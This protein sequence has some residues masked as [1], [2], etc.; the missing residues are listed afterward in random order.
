MAIRRKSRRKRVS[1]QA[2][3]AAKI[4][5][6]RSPIKTLK[7]QHKTIKPARTLLRKML[8]RAGPPKTSKRARK[9]ATF[10][11]KIPRVKRV[12]LVRGGTR[13]LPRLAARKKKTAPKKSPFRVRKILGMGG[14]LIEI[15]H[16]ISY[17]DYKTRFKKLLSDPKYK[18]LKAEYPAVTYSIYGHP[19]NHRLPSLEALLAWFETVYE[20]VLK[21][22][23]STAA[24]R[25]DFFAH[26]VIYG[27]KRNYKV[28]PSIRD[29]RGKIR[30]HRRVSATGRS[31]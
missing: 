7:R 11:K 29:Q 21:A 25:S 5:K 18:K 27:V 4:R 1:S 6:L 28:A 8:R 31:L 23:Q 17:R 9:L 15:M 10:I 19:G 22:M 2:E 26:L 20:P 3:I 13:K 24:K 30:K 14:E 12:K 16:P